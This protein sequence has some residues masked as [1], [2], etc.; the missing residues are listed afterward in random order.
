MRALSLFEPLR[1]RD[2]NLY[3]TGRKRAEVP[4]R[5]MPDAN[6]T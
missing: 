5:P 6:S 4:G 1:W 3:R 2:I